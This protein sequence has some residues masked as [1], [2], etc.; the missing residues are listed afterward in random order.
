[1]SDVMKLKL[2]IHRGTTD[3]GG[4]EGDPTGIVEIQV[5]LDCNPH[6]QKDAVA[7]IKARIKERSLITSLL[8]LDL[9]NQCMQYNG[10]QFQLCVIE[11]VLKRILKM[12][13][14]NKGN[15]PRVQ[16]KAAHLIKHW[17]SAYS[18]DTRLNEFVLAGKELAKRKERAKT[19]A[20]PPRSSST[21][22]SVSSASK[23]STSK[24]ITPTASA[25]IGGGAILQACPIQLMPAPRGSGSEE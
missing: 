10:I 23:A 16:Q 24:T 20:P 11:K 2:A 21:S 9:L 5:L 12:A 3:H 22:S 4:E 19:A 17:S 18:N 14:P 8:A 25:A 6:L 1:M 7:L 13:L 15:H